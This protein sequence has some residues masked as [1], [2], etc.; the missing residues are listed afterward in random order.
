MTFRGDFSGFEI[1]AVLAHAACLPDHVVEVKG[2]FY[3][4][5]SVGPAPPLL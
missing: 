4:V 5:T 2:V 1:I 3:D